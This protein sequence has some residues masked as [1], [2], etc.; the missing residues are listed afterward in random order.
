MK[1]ESL[2]PTLHLATEREERWTVL[3][4][5]MNWEAAIA[6]DWLGADFYM[7]EDDG[8]DGKRAAWIIN[9]TRS[10]VAKVVDGEQA[11]LIVNDVIAMGTAK[12]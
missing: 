10:S 12:P 8:Q 9:R 5:W 2:T 11:A 3:D 6:W 1:R 7:D 4:D